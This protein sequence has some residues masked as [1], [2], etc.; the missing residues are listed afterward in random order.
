MQPQLM[1][2]FHALVRVPRSPIW[3]GCQLHGK[4]I[5]ENHVQVVA[6]AIRMQ[7]MLVYRLLALA[8]H[9][10]GKQITE[11]HVQAVAE[12]MKMHI[13]ANTVIGTHRRGIL[14]VQGRCEISPTQPHQ[15]QISRKQ[16]A[17]GKAKGSDVQFPGRHM[18]IQFSLAAQ[19][20]WKGSP[21]DSNHSMSNS[22]VM[23]SPYPW[24]A[25]NDVVIKYH[26][27]FMTIHQSVCPVR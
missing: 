1:Q 6:N 20:P 4:I 21:V 13:Q 19:M 3:I 24:E 14:P 12:V 7:F 16:I 11:S 22:I 9:L 25:P 15:T 10:N 26:T 27:E 23:Q 17:T 2:W 18:T 8:C 5:T